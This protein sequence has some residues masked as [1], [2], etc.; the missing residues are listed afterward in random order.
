MRVRRIIPNVVLL[1]SSA[2]LAAEGQQ[3]ARETPQFRAGVELYQLDVTVLDDKR[4]PV[5]GLKEGEFTV[6]INGDLNT[7]VWISGGTRFL[8][9]VRVGRMRSFSNVSGVTFTNPSS[10]MYSGV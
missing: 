3:A 9:F 6:L 2:V 1:L 10:V 4:V 5:R 8:F 7:I